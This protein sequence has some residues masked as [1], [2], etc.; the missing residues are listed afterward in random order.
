MALES[1]SS[2]AFVVEDQLAGL[3]IPMVIPGYAFAHTSLR[4]GFWFQ[5]SA[6]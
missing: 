5:A 2:G 6:I 4:G 1:G 3:I